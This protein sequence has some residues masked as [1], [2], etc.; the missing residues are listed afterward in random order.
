VPYNFAS[1]RFASQLCFHITRPYLSLIRSS[2]QEYENDA[3]AITGA[4]ER[5]KAHGQV[6][7]C[8]LMTHKAQRFIFPLILL[9]GPASV[10]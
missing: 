9:P 8:G 5:H 3:Y 6:R 2:S 4:F 1:V 7:P 10:G